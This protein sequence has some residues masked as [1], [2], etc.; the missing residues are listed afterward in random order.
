MLTLSLVAA[1]AELSSSDTVEPL[2]SSNRMRE[3]VDG[4]YKWL[5]ECE[6]E[7]FYERMCDI[8]MFAGIKHV[9]FLAHPDSRPF[10]QELWKT[11]DGDAQCKLG[12]LLPEPPQLCVR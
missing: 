6:L 10:S 7:S 9:R 8:C 1:D 12:S 2:M 4:L 3:D 11:M 5:V